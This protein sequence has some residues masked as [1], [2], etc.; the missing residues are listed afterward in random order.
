MINEE[1]V[2]KL[3][4]INASLSI[5]GFVKNEGLTVEQVRQLNKRLGE[6]IKELRA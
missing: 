4:K 2:D 5:Q 6:I 1:I 3:Y